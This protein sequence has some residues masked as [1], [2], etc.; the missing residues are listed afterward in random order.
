MPRA[1]AVIC[2]ENPPAASGDFG[3]GDFVAEVVESSDEVVSALIAVGASGVPVS[4]E[5]VVVV[6]E[7]VPAN[8]RST[9]SA[10]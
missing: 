7:E 9:D 1:V 6:R 2:K 10:G 8:P 3:E 4:Y 5:V